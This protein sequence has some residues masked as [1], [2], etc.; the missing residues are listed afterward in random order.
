MHSQFTSVQSQTMTRT[1]FTGTK[2]SSIAACSTLELQMVGYNKGTPL[3][4]E[5]NYSYVS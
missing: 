1:L 4:Y 5:M 3:Q 2:K